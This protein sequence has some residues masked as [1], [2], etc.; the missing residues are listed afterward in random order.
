MRKL[1]LL[2]VIIGFLLS[3]TAENDKS[4]STLIQQDITITNLESYEYN[5]GIFGDEEEAEI[6]ELKNDF[7]S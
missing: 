5:L 4:N 6:S 3:C 1:I 2:L 7:N